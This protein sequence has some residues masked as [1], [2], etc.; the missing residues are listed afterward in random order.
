MS[1][2]SDQATLL[3]RKANIEA[4]LSAAWTQFNALLADNVESYSF[5]DGS[6]RQ[7]SKRRDV[8][9]VKKII[10]ML[11]ADLENV[12]QLLECKGGV[13]SLKM[14]RLGGRYY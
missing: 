5:D 13:V 7:S 2:S 6:G 10:D 4:A 11:D 12:N 14:N 9:K 3:A 8:E 1:C